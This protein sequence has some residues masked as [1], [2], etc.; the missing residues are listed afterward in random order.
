MKTL[1]TLIFIL[2]SLTLLA[3]DGIYRSSGGAI[4]PT[5][6]TSIAMQKEV[7]SFTVREQVAQVDIQFEFNNPETEART[8]LVGF[9]APGPEGDVSE[10]MSNSSQISDFTIVQ[11]G[12]ILPY[13][14]KVAD[15]EN[16]ELKEPGELQ[17]NSIDPGVFVYLFEM[18]FEP[19]INRVHHSYRFNA[20]TNV[21]VDEM[22]DYILTTGSKWAGGSI[23]DLTVNIDLGK[24]QYFYVKDVFGPEAEWSVVGA[25][26]VTEQQAAG[27]PGGAKMIRILSG[28][29]QVHVSNLSPEQNIDFGVMSRNSFSHT[30]LFFDTPNPKMSRALWTLSLDEEYSNEELR[31][32]RNTIFAQYGYVFGSPDLQKY[33][34][35]FAWY[36]PNPNLKMIDIKLNDKEK[37][38]IDAIIEQENL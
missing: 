27:I 8:L 9:Q 36:M 14:L 17:F 21:A 18:T 12:M 4:Y 32:M 22:Y 35:Q 34:S 16:C 11:N 25:G 7:L 1:T 20:S 33:F 3:N 37:A 19:G 2:L 29:L 23:G 24:N 28:H 30:P 5:Q 15:C 6:E 10:E 31:I 38:F 13:T 26:K